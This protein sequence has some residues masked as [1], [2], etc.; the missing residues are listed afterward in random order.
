MFSTDTSNR[1]AKYWERMGRLKLWS[2]V[3]AHQ[4]L[5]AHQD[6]QNRQTE[7]EDAFIRRTAWGDHGTVK[8]GDDMGG[9]T[10]LGDVMNQPP[11]IINNPPSPS[12]GGLAK[13]LAGVVIGALIPG[14]GIGGYVASKLL[15][16][17]P[18]APITAPV[19]SETIGVGLSHLVP[20]P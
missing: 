19:D 9:N 8:V 15:T 3:Q 20:E 2:G 1:I 10:I 5:Q 17:A 13:T 6:R 11:V 7:A 18:V 12:G 4:S 14:A 16:P